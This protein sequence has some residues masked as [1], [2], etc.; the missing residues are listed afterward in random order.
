MVAFLSVVLAVILF[1][2]IGN[3][4]R[5]GNIERDPVRKYLAVHSGSYRRGQRVIRNQIL[6]GVFVT[7]LLIYFW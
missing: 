2:V 1:M 7:G 6:T 5:M 4:V 3:L